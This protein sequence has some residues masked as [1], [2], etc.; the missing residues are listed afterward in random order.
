MEIEKDDVKIPSVI[1]QILQLITRITTMMAVL[2]GAAFLP[3]A[4]YMTIDAMSRRMGGPFTGV[5]DEIAGQVLA[6]GGTWAMAYALARGAHVRIDVMMPVYPARLREFLT[7]IAIASTILLGFILAINA[8]ALSYESYLLD[9][10]AYS[11]LGQ[12]LVYAQSLTAI[13]FT[14]LT[15]QAFIMLIVGGFRFAAG[16]PVTQTIATGDIK[17]ET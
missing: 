6:F 16:V 1:W 7:L 12:P 9:A 8:W 15:L 2:A 10:R 3:L 4:F 5:S 11:M 13:G 17:R 14:M